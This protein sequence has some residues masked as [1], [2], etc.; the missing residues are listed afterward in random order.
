MKKRDVILEKYYCINCGSQV[1]SLY[2]E[3]SP[4]VLKLTKCPSCKRIADKYVEYDLVIVV[5]DLILLRIMAYRHILL[6]SEF[7]IFWKI[8]IGLIFLETYSDWIFLKESSSSRSLKDL[9]STLFQN[10]DLIYQDDLKFYEMSIKTALGFSSFII[11]A[12]FLT[13]GYSYLRKTEP[14]TFKVI[15]KAVALSTCGSILLLPSLIWETYIQEFHVLFVSMYTTLS[16]LLAHK[17][18]SNSE[19]IWSLLVI[20]LA[21]VVKMFIMNTTLTQLVINSDYLIIK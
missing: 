3:Y 6:N 15:W 19:K 4:S 9:N 18:I 7:K 21:H 1:K 10:K 8:S 14:V 20:F 12:Y 13:A 5:I 2:K 17:A 16:Q 11:V